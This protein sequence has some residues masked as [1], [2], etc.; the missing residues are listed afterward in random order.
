MNVHVPEDAGLNYLMPPHPPTAAVAASAATEER[1]RERMESLLVRILSELLVYIPELGEFDLPYALDTT[2]M[3]SKVVEAL[4]KYGPYGAVTDTYIN[5]PA[6]PSRPGHPVGYT[7][8]KRLYL[9]PKLDLW[10]P[11]LD[12]AKGRR[13]T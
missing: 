12:A 2:G 9:A 6:L 11:L 5:F 7:P 3:P 4:I 10:R 1:E 13:R 8:A